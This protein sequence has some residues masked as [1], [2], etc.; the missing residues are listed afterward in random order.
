MP[1]TKLCGFLPSKSL[2]NVWL[3]RYLL[4]MWVPKISKLTLPKIWVRPVVL[5]S[6][7]PH[8]MKMIKIEIVIKV[9]NLRS[10]NFWQDYNVYTGRKKFKSIGTYCNVFESALELLVTICNSPYCTGVCLNESSFF[11]ELSTRSS[12]QK[13]KGP[14]IKQGWTK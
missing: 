7:I 1:I 9:R 3:Y 2:S 12:L 4:S 6:K 14:R 11:L 8:F 10:R 13:V 5:L